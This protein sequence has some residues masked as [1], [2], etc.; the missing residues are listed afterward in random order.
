MKML[1][2]AFV[3]AA[4]LAAGGLAMAQMDMKGGGHAGHQAAARSAADDA[5]TR[6]YREV[7]D[8]M[9]RDMNIA[10]S[11]DADADFMRAMIPHHEGAVAMARVALEHGSDAEV[12]DLAQKVIA[13]QESEIAQM[14]SW[15]N[16]NRKPE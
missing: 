13:A 3:A 15:L 8:R 7:N 2:L 10:F 14:R 12:R 11:G 5:S 1:S 6:A 4:V 9:H 16:R